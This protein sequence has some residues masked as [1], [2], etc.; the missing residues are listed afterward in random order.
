MLL[1]LQNVTVSVSHPP[2]LDQINL[3]IEKNERIA[4]VGRNGMGKSTLMK[5]L[6][7]IEQPDS[8]EFEL[9]P[10]CKIAMLQQDVPRDVTAS[11]YDVV[12]QGLQAT[13]YEED[14]QI[15]H[16]VDTVLSKLNLDGELAFADLSGGLKRRV[17]LAKALVC[18]PDLLLL[19]EPTNHLDISAIEWLEETLQSL[20]CAVLFV[21]HDRTFTRNLAKRIIEL[22]RGQLSDWVGDFDNYLRRKEEALHAE[23]LANE[24]FDKKLA[25]EEVWIRQG[26]KARR[27]RNE[28]RVR[29]L[30]AMRQEYAERRQQLGKV[31]ATVQQSSQGGQEVIVAEQLNFCFPDKPSEPMVTNFSTT[32]LKGD[33]VGIVGPNGAGKTTL[34]QL[35]LKRLAP[36]TGTVKHGTNLELA[37]FDQ[38]REQLDPKQTV[39]ENVGGG[40]DTVTINGKSKH[41]M[42]YLRDFLFAPERANSNI[43]FLSGGEKNRLLLA[44]LFLKPVNLLVLDEPTNDLDFETL[45]L[46]EECMSEFKG[47]IILISHDRKFLDNV[48]T[49]VLLLQGGGQIESCV[50]DY[51]QW[52]EMLKKPAATADEKTQRASKP[53]SDKPNTKPKK[54]SYNDKRELQALPKKIEALEAELEQLQEKLASPDF[55]Q[56]ADPDAIKAANADLAT[57]QDVL[58]KLYA[59]WGELDE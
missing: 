18:E 8:G 6:A 58:D 17:L 1:R 50:G 39:R 32:V 57:K 59:R 14:W 4:L 9:A 21:S 5:L 49:E 51:E 54:L 25:E 41:I 31:K 34:V 12:A 26:I 52:G 27:T 2:L 30:K 46:L 28:G 56:S 53:S 3:V 10:H 23:A 43:E 33:K 55:Y 44:K 16:K 19:D 36:D 35:L 29:A 38:L 37:Y 20:R 15:Q 42:S 47:T 7:G 11:I 48:C 22:D 40:S 24:R 45:E 13:D